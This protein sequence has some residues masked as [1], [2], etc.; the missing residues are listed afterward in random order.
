MC[1]S[2]EPQSTLTEGPL[3]PDINFRTEAVQ[4]RFRVTAFPTPRLMETRYFEQQPDGTS[5]GVLV[6][7]DMIG[8]TCNAADA[9][10]SD[11]RC[12]VTVDNVG[13]DNAGFYTVVIGNDIGNLSMQ[14][15][16]K[17]NGE[18]ISLVCVVSKW[19]D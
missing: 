19:I 8:V 5:L 2:G 9:V 7:K 12:N 10:S 11:V 3:I 13:S 14:F 1:V 17:V 6:T 15:Q 16:I 4:H 18:C